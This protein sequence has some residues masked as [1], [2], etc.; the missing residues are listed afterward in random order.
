[1]SLAPLTPSFPF[2]SSMTL[3]V[4]YPPLALQ[5]KLAD[6][7][8]AAGFIVVLPNFFNGDP[9]NGDHAPIPVWRKA[10]APV[11]SFV[12]MQILNILFVCNI[13]PV[14]SICMYVIREFT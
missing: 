13:S 6:K 1:M 12:L 2:F 7:I 10:H 4:L 5:K 9:F 11:G 3:L 8:A 14:T